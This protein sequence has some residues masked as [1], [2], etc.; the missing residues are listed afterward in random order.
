MDGTTQIIILLGLILTLV[1]FARIVNRK[2]KRK[3]KRR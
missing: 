2:H 3:G 1:I